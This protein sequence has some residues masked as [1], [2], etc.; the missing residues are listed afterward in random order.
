MDHC[1]GAL[2]KYQS[3]VKMKMEN[4]SGILRKEFLQSEPS[5]TY[6]TR[7]DA[8][9]VKS[10]VLKCKRKWGE[11]RCNVCYQRQTISFHLSVLEQVVSVLIKLRKKGIDAALIFSYKQNWKSGSG[12]YCVFSNLGC[13]GYELTFLNNLCG[14]VMKT[15]YGFIRK[16][17]NSQLTRIEEEFERSELDIEPEATEE[18]ESQGGEDERPR[19]WRHDSTYESSWKRERPQWGR[20][21]NDERSKAWGDWN[22]NS[23]EYWGDW[24]GWNGVK[25]SKSWR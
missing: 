14:T 5:R 20:T 12:C 4:D 16:T 10:A 17:Y 25:T 13:T 1:P 2:D 9:E 22:K 11:N 24:K 15:N 21:R 18:S 8:G 19:A 23:G 3:D 6:Q 7:S